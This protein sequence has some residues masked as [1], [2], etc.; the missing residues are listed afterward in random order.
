MELLIFSDSHG[1]NDGMQEAVDRQVGRVDAVIFLGDGLRDV[2][3]LWTDGATLFSVRGNC[4]WFSDAST[5]TE[6]TVCFE[7][8]R[9]FFTHGHLYGVKGRV[10]GLVARAAELDA[11]IVL[12]GHTHT[13][14]SEVIPAG[15]VI[16]GRSLPRPMYLFNPGS[17]GSADTSFGTL[18]LQSNVVLFSHGTIKKGLL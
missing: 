14:Y 7:G 2:D 9:L 18:S 11:D 17:I 13:P 6:Q 15:S 4:D 1:K 3:R 10:G 5:E 12:F 16:A 8:H